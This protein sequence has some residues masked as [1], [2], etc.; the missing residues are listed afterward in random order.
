MQPTDTMRNQ[1]QAPM[2]LSS[3]RRAEEICGPVWMPTC[4]AYSMH[5]RVQFIL[6]QNKFLV[7]DVGRACLDTGLCHLVYARCLRWSLMQD[8]REN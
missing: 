2:R 3:F 4:T 6:Q 7:T 1:L 5:P 8:S